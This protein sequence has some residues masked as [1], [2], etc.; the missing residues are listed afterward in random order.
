MQSAIEEVTT[1][2]IAW[3][4][5]DDSILEKLVPLIHHELHRLARHYMRRER[6]GHTLQTTALVNEAYLRLVDGR[7]V[8]FQNRTHFFAVS[9]QVMRRVP[10][11]YASARRNKKRGGDQQRIP[12]DESIAGSSSQLFD[13][14]QLDEAMNRLAAF[15]PRQAQVVELQYFGGLQESEIAEFLRIAPRTVRQDWSTARAWLYRE[16]SG[17]SGEGNSLEREA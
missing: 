16:L 11:D 8:N 7:R 12:L 4:R 3:S 1:L 13:L 17:P 6:N 9:S 10:V 2:L 15:S 5:G 14:L